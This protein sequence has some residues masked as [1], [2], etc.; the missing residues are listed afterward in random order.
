MPQDRPTARIIPVM[1][2][3][4]QRDHVGPCR[5]GTLDEVLWDRREAPCQAGGRNAL[6]GDLAHRGHVHDDPPEV[7][8][9]TP[10][11][12]REAAWPPSH[13]QQATVGGEIT[14]RG[15]LLSLEN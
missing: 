8:V 6:L 3:P 4:A 1:E 5:I 13:V 7:G 11:R 2:N 12:D 9:V 14:A 15:N 10:D